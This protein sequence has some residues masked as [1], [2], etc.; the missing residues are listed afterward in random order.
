MSKEKI[1]TAIKEVYLEKQGE[2]ISDLE[3]EI[4]FNAMA[5]Q[6]KHEACAQEIQDSMVVSV[7]EDTRTV[8]VQFSTSDP[9]LQR[10]FAKEKG[11]ANRC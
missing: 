7:E 11:G 4:I 5:I 8:K 9:E 2:V 3:A 1:V 10:L 6:L